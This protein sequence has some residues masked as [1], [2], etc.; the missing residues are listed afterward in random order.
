MYIATGDWLSVDKGFSH[1]CLCIYSLSYS[2][3]GYSSGKMG[4][5]C[6]ANYILVAVAKH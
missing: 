2:M 3:F 5:T 6:M 4:C 1:D